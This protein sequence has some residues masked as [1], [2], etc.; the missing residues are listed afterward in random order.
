MKCPLGH[1]YDIEDSATV[2]TI[3]FKD[4]NG[5]EERLYFCRKCK[6]VFHVDEEDFE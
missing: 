4:E 1:T 3:D 6:V 2:G 5:E